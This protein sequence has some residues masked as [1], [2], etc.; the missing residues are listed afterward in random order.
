MVTIRIRIIFFGISVLTAC[1]LITSCGATAGITG[2][3][4]TVSLPETAV[5]EQETSGRV[6]TTTEERTKNVVS[7]WDEYEASERPL[8]AVLPDRGIYLYGI[9]TGGVELFM[10]DT[11]YYFGWSYLTPRFILPGIQ[12]GDF[13]SDGTEELAVILYVGS[14]T[15]VSIEDL[16]IVEM[17]EES[18]PSDNQPHKSG[19]R[20][21]KDYVFNPEDYVSQ[22]RKA[23]GFKT[24]TKAG[25]LMGEISA[26]TIVHT[27]NLK[28]YQSKEYGRI[29]DTL[30]F[31]SIVRFTAENKRLAAE[32]AAGI[33]CESFAAPVYIGVVN[34]DVK[35]SAGKFILENLRFKEEQQ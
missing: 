18:E 21:F 20:S 1:L 22:L 24:Y 29:G 13:D 14:G 8:I 34:A 31:G 6:E 27:V 28:E 35:Y 7:S 17:D 3:K 11:G 5:T 33:T 16:H 12:A 4:R 15:G 23:V 26:G 32:F 9:K 30:F 19:S 25:E 10:G 2:G